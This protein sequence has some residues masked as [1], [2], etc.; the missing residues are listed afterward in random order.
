M[1]IVDNKSTD[2]TRSVAEHFCGNNR[3]FP[4]LLRS[5]TWDGLN[6]RNRGWQEASSEWVGYID[7][8]AKA[9]PHW[10]KV[11][12]RIT[13]EERPEIFGGPYYGF[14]HGRKPGWFKD[15][16]ESDYLGPTAN[17]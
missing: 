17:P 16:Y 13:S 1:L 2:D 10:L 3:G 6:A 7:D 9:P 5:P 15:E 12:H 4:L 14:L 11:A 8:D